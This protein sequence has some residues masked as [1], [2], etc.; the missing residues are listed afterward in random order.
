MG[1]V[2]HGLILLPVVLSIIG[3]VGN[4]EQ[5]IPRRHDHYLSMGEEDTEGKENFGNE[6]EE[7][8]PI[9]D[10]NGSETQV[11]HVPLDDNV[12]AVKENNTKGEE[13][14]ISEEITDV[15]QEETFISEEKDSGTTGLPMPSY[16]VVKE[17]S[18]GKLHSVSTPFRTLSVSNH[19]TQ[20]FSHSQ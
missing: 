18:Q 9:D 20:S 13:N 3:P 6:A 14:E 2:C 8:I 4:P 12:D 19:S 10:M 15:Q 5:E 1:S 17:E 16:M 7:K 11:V